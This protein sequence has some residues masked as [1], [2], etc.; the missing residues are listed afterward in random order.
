VSR[1]KD[2]LNLAG[3][4]PSANEL[5]RVLRTLFTFISTRLFALEQRQRF[6]A[7]T[8]AVAGDRFIVYHTLGAV[9]TDVTVLPTADCRVWATD[10]DRALWTSSQVILRGSAVSTR[11][12]GYVEL[13]EE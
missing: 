1:N 9:P 2:H 7:Y 12:H 10:A 3:S 8:A 13:I 6:S 11:V 4:F 5:A